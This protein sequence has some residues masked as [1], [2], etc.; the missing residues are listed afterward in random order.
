[1]VEYHVELVGRRAVQVHI[2]L[3]RESERIPQAR[4]LLTAWHHDAQVVELCE[5]AKGAELSLN[6]SE[7]IRTKTPCQHQ[8]ALLHLW[9]QRNVCCLTS[10]DARLASRLRVISTSITLYAFEHANPVRSFPSSG[11]EE[12]AS[13]CAASCRQL[14]QQLHVRSQ[15]N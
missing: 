11:P 8:S 4:F 3:P 6:L 1:M 15:S 12:D 5:P 2:V 7:D 9:K 10:G 13:Q 14:A